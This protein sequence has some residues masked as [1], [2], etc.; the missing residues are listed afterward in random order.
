MVESG[1]K[2]RELKLNANQKNGNSL[3]VKSKSDKNN[4]NI[5]HP[6]VSGIKDKK[7]I[8]K[9]KTKMS[10]WKCYYCGK[11]GHIKKNCYEYIRKQKQEGNASI[12]T[13][14][15]T[16][17]LSKVLTVSS[18]SVYD[19]CILDSGCSFHMSPNKEW[20]KDFNANETGIVYMGNNHTCKIMGFGNITLKLH[21]GRIRLLKWS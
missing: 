20:F 3:F 8:K 18:K 15:T 11:L 10:T 7:N 17:C 16:T 19:E 6:S 9:G 5:L 2:A 14:E 21:D 13:G 1:W 4:H 12:A